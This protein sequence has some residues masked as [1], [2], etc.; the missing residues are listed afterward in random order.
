MGKDF[1]EVGGKC[2]VTF[3]ALILTFSHLFLRILFVDP[4]KTKLPEDG[5]YFD[6]CGKIIISA[7]AI[8]FCD[9]LLWCWG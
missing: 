5:K 6:L 1:N 7:L 9:F 4:E 8:V 3:I 2:I